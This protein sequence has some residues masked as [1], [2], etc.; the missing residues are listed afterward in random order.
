MVDQT[1]TSDPPPFWT[2]RKHDISRKR[3]LGYVSDAQH[4]LDPSP[5]F[6]FPDACLVKIALPRRRIS[7]RQRRVVDFE[8]AHREAP[9]SVTQMKKSFR[10]GG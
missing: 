2:G 1:V 4:R 7:D 10:F 9:A 6:R 8:G 5:Y 3:P